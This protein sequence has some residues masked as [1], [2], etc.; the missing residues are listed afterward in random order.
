MKLTHQLIHSAGTGGIGFN[1]HQLRVLGIPWPPAKGWLSSLIGR[2]IPD[3]QWNLVL[4]LKGKRRAD[5]R[6]ILNGTRF[7]RAVSQ[8]PPRKRDLRR[9]LMELEELVSYVR[10]YVTIEIAA[11]GNCDCDVPAGDCPCVYCASEHFNKRTE[12][13]SRFG[14]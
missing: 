13:L 3:D 7:E 10:E 1:F 8:Q 12:N 5:R 4:S 14:H 9:M 2:E 6:R 11:H